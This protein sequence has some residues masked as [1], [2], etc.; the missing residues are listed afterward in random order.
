MS[1]TI[2]ATATGSTTPQ[3]AVGQNVV[4]GDFFILYNRNPIAIAQ[5]FETGDGEDEETLW[6]FFFNEHPDFS[7]FTKNLGLTS[8]LLTLTLTPKDVT[9][10]GHSNDA[11]WIESLGFIGGDPLSDGTPT[12]PEIQTLTAGVKT[13]VMIDLLKYGYTA[14]EILNVLFSSFGGRISMWYEDDALISFAQL[15]LT[16]ESP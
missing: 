16:Q 14:E 2:S 10:N 3:T 15:D 12:L 9:T 4:N 11:I 7:K 13:T 5:G 6:T 1:I 8:A